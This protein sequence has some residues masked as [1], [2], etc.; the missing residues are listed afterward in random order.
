MATSLALVNALPQALQYRWIYD[1]VD[2]AAALRTQEELIAD[3][4]KDATLRQLLES[5]TTNEAWNTLKLSLSAA[6]HVGPKRAPLEIKL[7]TF[8]GVRAIRVSGS[9]SGI[10]GLATVELRMM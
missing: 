8:D 10:I 7:G 3:C 1:G 2:S 4:R 5:A 6:R 9:A